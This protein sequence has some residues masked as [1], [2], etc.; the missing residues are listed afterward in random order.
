M[1]IYLGENK[2]KIYINKMLYNFDIHTSTP[3]TNAIRLLSSDNF[4]LK[5]RN[6]VFITVKKED[7]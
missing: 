7:E 1:A 3:I 5:D 2:Y 6:G 4:T